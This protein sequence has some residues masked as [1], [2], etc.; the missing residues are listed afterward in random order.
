[1]VLPGIKIMHSF[2]M[3]VPAPGNYLHPRPFKEH[4]HINTIHMKKNFTIYAALLL[5]TL[6]TSS[7]ATVRIRTNAAQGSALVCKECQGNLTRWFWGYLY[8]GE[9][10]VNNCDAR[11]LQA[12]QVKTS[13]WQGFVTVL[14]LGI[15]CPVTVNWSCAKEQ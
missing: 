2:I 13:F 1:M 7:C 15:Y 6:E 14:T 8:N 11:A 9:Y 12:V 5:L 3:M 4:L 10:M